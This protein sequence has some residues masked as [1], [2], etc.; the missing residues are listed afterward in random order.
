M[1]ISLSDIPTDFQQKVAV[2]QAVSGPLEELTVDEICK[3]AGISRSKFYEL[4]SSKYDIGYWY[5]NLVYDLTLGRVGSSLSWREG[6][7]SCLDLMDQQR[8]YFRYTA[9]TP[10][11]IPNLFWAIRADRIKALCA[12][13]NERNVEITPK[14]RAEVELYA[15]AVDFLLRR[16]VENDDIRSVEAFTDLWLECTPDTLYKALDNI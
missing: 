10:D 6:I 12:L 7:E 1:Q 3:S 5:L 11:N 14:L 16:W 15:T 8:M 13:L 2:M 9:R 4:F